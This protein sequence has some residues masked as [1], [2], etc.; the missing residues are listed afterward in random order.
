MQLATTAAFRKEMVKPKAETNEKVNE[1]LA[2][3]RQTF[4][5]RQAK[6]STN[7]T[8]LNPTAILFC[9]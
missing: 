9:G 1:H 2:T 5:E 7:H 3:K 8:E 4:I 6:N